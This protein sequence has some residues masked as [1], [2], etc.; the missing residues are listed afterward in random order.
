MTTNPNLK[1]WVDFLWS[2]CVPAM[3]VIG[4]GAAACWA[5]VTDPWS[6]VTLWFLFSLA[7]G[8][9]GRMQ[10]YRGEVAAQASLKTEVKQA[11]ENVGLVPQPPP[12]PPARRDMS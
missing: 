5:S 8:R 4:L 12:I 7:I 9:Y 10:F 1:R 2:E 11:F 3:T 6:R